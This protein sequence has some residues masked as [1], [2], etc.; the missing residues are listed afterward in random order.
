[1]QVNMNLKKEQK[2]RK[3]EQ[4]EEELQA[5]GA[6]LGKAFLVSPLAGAPDQMLKLYSG[7]R[8]LGG[9]R[10]PNSQASVFI[11]LDSRSSP[12]TQVI[13]LISLGHYCTLT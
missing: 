1:M 2:K 10:G 6:T 5:A 12:N 3:F 7:R 11:R 4:E 8:V 13:K 9:R